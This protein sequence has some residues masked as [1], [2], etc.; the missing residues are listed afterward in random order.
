MILLI[1]VLLI[2]VYIL[3]KY[4]KGNEHFYSFLFALILVLIYCFEPFLYYTKEIRIFL[5]ITI[6]IYVFF[7][8]YFPLFNKHKEKEYLVI[9]GCGLLD[10]KRLSPLLMNRLN[11]AYDLYANKP[12]KIVVSGG[13]GKDEDISEASAMKSYL[14]HKGVKEK[15]ILCEEKSKSTEENLKYSKEIIGHSFMIITSDYHAL[16]VFILSKLLRINASIKTSKTIYYYKFYAMVREYLAI[17]YLFKGFMIGYFLFLTFNHYF[18][19]NF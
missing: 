17:L 3:K 10:K 7:Q 12:C 8:V 13:K 1:L 18:L 2:N 19:F 11:V 16:R 6:P 9:L 15:D 4:E 5:E 14:I